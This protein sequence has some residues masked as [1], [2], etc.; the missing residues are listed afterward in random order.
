MTFCKKSVVPLIG[1]TSGGTNPLLEMNVAGLKQNAEQ[2]SVVVT[3]VV[4][5]VGVV[6]SGIVRLPIKNDSRKESV[7]S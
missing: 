6:I 4:N 1:E 7:G 2:A 3:A 5:I